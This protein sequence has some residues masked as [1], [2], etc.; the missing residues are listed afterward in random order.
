MKWKKSA[1][2]GLVR[3]GFPVSR[4]SSALNV[5]WPQSFKGLVDESRRLKCSC[6]ELCFPMSS[7]IS[8]GQSYWFGWR[9]WDLGCYTA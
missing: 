6:G 1:S 5:G 9:A 8:H 7:R 4:A 2:I 3:F